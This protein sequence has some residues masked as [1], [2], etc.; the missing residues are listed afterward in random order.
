MIEKLLNKYIDFLISQYDDEK[1][2]FHFGEEVT[3]N[4]K[5]RVRFSCTSEE[6]FTVV[7]YYEYGI[8]TDSGQFLANFWLKEA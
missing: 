3:W 2:R 4:W 1:V 6:K 7:G 8:E 5:G